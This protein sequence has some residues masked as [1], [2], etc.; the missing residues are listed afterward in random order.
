M[1]PPKPPEQ[2]KHSGLLQGQQ[3][4]PQ[5]PKH[6]GL[7]QGHWPRPRELPKHSE[8]NWQGCWPRG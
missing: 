7:P 8:P 2:P 4:P 1:G 6:S 5:G 3:R